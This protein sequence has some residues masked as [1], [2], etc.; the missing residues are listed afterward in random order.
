MPQVAAVATVVSAVAS[1]GGAVLGA[2]EAKKRAKLAKRQA[3]LN[4]QRQERQLRAQARRRR[5]QLFAK[6]A[7]TGAQFSSPFSQT[8]QAIGTAEQRELGVSAQADAIT[9]AQI[10]LDASS[11]VTRSIIGGI[12]G[13]SSLATSDNISNLQSVF[14][15]GQQFSTGAGSI[16]GSKGG[17][18]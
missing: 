8:S 18:G 11:G 3:A 5:A 13:L 17:L 9:Q 12:S 15:G 14:G 7:V 6:G 10:N 2:Q 4:K 16:S 1:I